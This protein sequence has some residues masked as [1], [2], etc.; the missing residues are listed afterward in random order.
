MF[1][2]LPMERLLIVDDDAAHLRTVGEIFES[3]FEV[4]LADTA[5]EGLRIVEEIR[6][7]HAVISDLDLPGMSGVDLLERIR[8]V[9][10]RIRRVLMS[11]QFS[12]PGFKPESVERAAAHEL[13]PKPIDVRRLRK[14]V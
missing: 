14:A 3:R 1:Y 8:K 4:M 5:E 7:I 6:G 2:I 9:E 10:E 13:I 12:D 11:A